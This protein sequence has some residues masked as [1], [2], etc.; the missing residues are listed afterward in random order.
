MKLGHRM[1]V[2]ASS[3]RRCWNWVPENDGRKQYKARGRSA[4]LLLVQ[5]PSDTSAVTSTSSSRS[6]QDWIPSSRISPQNA[7]DT[8]YCSPSIIPRHTFIYGST[9]LSTLSSTLA[10]C[11]MLYLLLWAVGSWHCFCIAGGMCTSCVW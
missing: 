4:K 5:L 3:H 11:G 6:R 2:S 8:L 7:S 9:I 10:Q 1:R